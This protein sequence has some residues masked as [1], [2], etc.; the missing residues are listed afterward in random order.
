MK[1]LAALFLLTTFGLGAAATAQPKP[2]WMLIWA[3]DGGGGFLTREFPSMEECEA[4]ADHIS[5]VGTPNSSTEG[6][7][8][9]WKFNYTRR[10]E[11][12]VATLCVPDPSEIEGIKDVLEEENLY[13]MM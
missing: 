5:K 12:R 2:V 8:G 7:K 13:R 11:P 1:G 9:A 6:I 3:N 4:V 10:Q